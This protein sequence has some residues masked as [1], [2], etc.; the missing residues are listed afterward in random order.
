MKYNCRWMDGRTM[1]RVESLSQLKTGQKGQPNFTFVF[2][3]SPIIN[4]IEVCEKVVIQRNYFH[5]RSKGILAMANLWFGH[6]LIFLT[7]SSRNLL[8]LWRNVQALWLYQNCRH[9]YGSLNDHDCFL[10]YWWLGNTSCY[11]LDIF[12]NFV[13]HTV[14]S[15]GQ[16]TFKCKVQGLSY[17]KNR[18]F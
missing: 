13:L 10:Q 18:L 17:Q 2:L 11:F 14:K 6:M 3:W 12:L 4:F 16:T 7:V 9:G 5:D 8:H 1:L 15:P